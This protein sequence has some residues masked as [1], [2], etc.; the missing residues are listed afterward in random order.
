[1]SWANVEDRR[2]D[3]PGAEKDT[4]RIVNNITIMLSLPDN[5]DDPLSVM[6]PLRPFLIH[7]NMLSGFVMLDSIL[8]D[9]QTDVNFINGKYRKRTGFERIQSLYRDHKFLGYTF[10]YPEVNRCTPIP[11]KSLPTTTSITI[12]REDSNNLR[13]IRYGYSVDDRAPEEEVEEKLEKV[14]RQLFG[15]RKKK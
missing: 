11:D 1:M 3:K 4:T 13:E 2:K 5:L 6:Y 7:Q 14:H 10:Y 15:P 8:I 9:A 12:I